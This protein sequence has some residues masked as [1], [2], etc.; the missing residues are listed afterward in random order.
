MSI[1]TVRC[2]QVSALARWLPMAAP[3]QPMAAA[4][5]AG[6]ALVASTPG[7]GDDPNLRL[8]FAGLLMAAGVAFVLDDRAAPTLASSPMSVVE[9]RLARMIVIVPMVAVWWILAI[10]LM[11]ACRADSLVPISS[12]SLE[13]AAY[14]ALALAGSVWS[15]RFSD[16][17]SGG[18]AGALLAVAVFGSSALPLPEWWPRL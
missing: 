17:G 4:G 11:A 15:Q 2:R 1:V 5:I 16:D 7:V 13:F 8:R 12:L 3:L 18:I 10:E 6:L 9:Q 14:L